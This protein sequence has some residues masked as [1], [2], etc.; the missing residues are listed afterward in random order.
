MDGIGYQFMGQEV[1][2]FWAVFRLRKRVWGG[3]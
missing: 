2:V 3:L 1:V